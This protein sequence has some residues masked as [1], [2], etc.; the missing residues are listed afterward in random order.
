MCLSSTHSSILYMKDLSVLDSVSPP[1]TN[2]CGHG[3]QLNHQMV[4]RMG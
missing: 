1:E 3:G 4:P 2:L